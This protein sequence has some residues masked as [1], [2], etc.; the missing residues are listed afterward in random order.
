[1]IGAENISQCPV[2][3]GQKGLS[4]LSL[5]TMK[6]AKEK[7]KRLGA[8]KGKRKGKGKKP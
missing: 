6:L 2:Q 1:M 4:G 5:K 8:E 7:G 3:G